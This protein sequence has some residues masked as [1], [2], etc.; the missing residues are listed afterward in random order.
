MGALGVGVEKRVQW[1]R[2]QDEQ[3]NDAHVDAWKQ[4]ENGYTRTSCEAR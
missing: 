2:E 4:R 3:K 1:T